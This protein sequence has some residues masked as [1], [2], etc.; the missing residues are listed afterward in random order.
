MKRAR[1]GAGS[2]R[3]R[4]KT[5]VALATIDDHVAAV[6]PS[7]SPASMERWLSAPG[8]CWDGDRWFGWSCLATLRDGLA[9]LRAEVAQLALDAAAV[10]PGVDV[11]EG[12][13]LGLVAGPPARAVDGSKLAYASRAMRRMAVFRFPV[14][15]ASRS[16]ASRTYRQAAGAYAVFECREDQ[17]GDTAIRHPSMRCENASPTMLA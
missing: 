12:R 8:W 13:V 6:R 15:E 16:M 3:R 9:L 5:T 7:E 17:V 2:R 11:G 14:C 10:V 4:Q 1:Q